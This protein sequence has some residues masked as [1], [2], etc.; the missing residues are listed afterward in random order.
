ML[1]SLRELVNALLASDRYTYHVGID[2]RGGA[3]KSTLAE[4]L[5]KQLPEAQVVHTDDFYRVMDPDTRAALTIAQAYQQNYDW[6]RLEQQVLAPLSQ[7]RPAQYQRYDWP[8]NALAETIEV[9]ASG[10]VIVEGV[11][12]LRPE[13]R[14]Y[15][16]LKVWVETSTAECRRRM[17]ARA[18]NPVEQIERWETIEQHYIDRDRPAEA[19]EHVLSGQ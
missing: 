4:Q 5:R 18:E 15:Y 8:T 10:V 3:G 16:D 1:L 2:G 19:A 6:Q 12:S 7:G 17:I 13:L 11:G 14:G 9:A